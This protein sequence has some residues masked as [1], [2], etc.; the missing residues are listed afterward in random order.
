MAALVYGSADHFCK[1]VNTAMSPN[2]FDASMQEYSVGTLKALYSDVNL[3]KRPVLNSIAQSNLGVFTAYYSNYMQRFDPTTS[4]TVGS[5]PD[6]CE[7]T[8]LD[9]EI[10]QNTINFTTAD[11]VATRVKFDDRLYQAMCDPNDTTTEG[12]EIIRNAINAL[13]SRINNKAIADYVALRGNNL[14]TGALTTGVVSVPFYIS[15]KPVGGELGTGLDEFLM[16]YSLIDAPDNLSPIA[17]GTGNFE[18][19]MFQYLKSACCNDNG[20]I[21][22]ADDVLAF[23]DRSITTV[24]GSQNQV[25]TWLPTFVQPLTMQLYGQEGLFGNNRN[26]GKFATPNAEFWRSTVLD[27]NTAQNPI[28]YDIEA[29]Y[30]G[31]NREDFGWDIAISTYFKLGVMPNDA[32]SATDPLNGVNYM[33]QFNATNI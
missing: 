23:K 11:L 2:G 17:V 6:F 12:M 22:T 9:R 8:F 15:T 1:K 19:Y 18:R 30:V 5:L 31:C 10:Y 33:I 16:Q 21:P 24:T 20:Y 29:K 7:D 13:N 14:S 27:M 32:Y 25:L 3:A 4:T 26:V 28:R